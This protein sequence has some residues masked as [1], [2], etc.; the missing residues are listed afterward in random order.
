MC[1]AICAFRVQGLGFRI[2]VCGDLYISDSRC[3]SVLHCV[4]MCCSLSRVLQR[5][6][7]YAALFAEGFLHLWPCLHRPNSTD[8]FMLLGAVCCSVLHGVKGAAEK[9]FLRSIVGRGVLPCLHRPILSNHSM[10][11]KVVVRMGAFG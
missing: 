4:A 5:S 2:C 9:C 1:V 3:C 11:H 10:S 8:H 7:S 6:E